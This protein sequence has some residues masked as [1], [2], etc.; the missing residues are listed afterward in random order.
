MEYS[1]H[2][3]VHKSV[4]KS[5]PEVIRIAPVDVC[6]ETE[7]AHITR[8]ALARGLDVQRI[9]FAVYT[10]VDSRTVLGREYAFI[11][12]V[13][14]LETLKAVRR[15]RGVDLNVLMTVVRL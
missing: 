4:H 3:A 14:L 11:R 15:G 6:L 7:S 5:A 1:P 13:C 10:D 2:H 9:G 8:P 12:F